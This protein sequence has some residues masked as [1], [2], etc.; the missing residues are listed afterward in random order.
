[1]ISATAKSCP[2]RR[3]CIRN[4]IG[5]TSASITRMCRIALSGTTGFGRKSDT[6]NGTTIMDDAGKLTEGKPE[7]LEGM[8]SACVEIGAVAEEKDPEAQRACFRALQ[9]GAERCKSCGAPSR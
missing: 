2:Q 5:P 3:T 9:R 6:T 1:M 4:S 7:E 8:L